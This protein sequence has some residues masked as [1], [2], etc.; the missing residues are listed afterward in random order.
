MA[1][2]RRTQETILAD[3]VR[4]WD[5]IRHEGFNMYTTCLAC[6]VMAH[7]RGKV[8]DAVRCEDCYTEGT[9]G[10]K[11]VLTVLHERLD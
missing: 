1:R 7:C 3:R 4:S 5:A 8:R 6:G 11:V 10:A 2:I 9:T